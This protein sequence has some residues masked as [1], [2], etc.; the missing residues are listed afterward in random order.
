[1]IHHVKT[2]CQAKCLK[3]S[4]NR[5]KIHIIKHFNTIL[6][7]ITTKLGLTHAALL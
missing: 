7:T 3:K 4:E 6:E 5:R 1:M 2:I